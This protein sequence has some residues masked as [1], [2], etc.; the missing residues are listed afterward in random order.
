MNSDELVTAFVFLIVSITG[1]LVCRAI[2]HCFS[3]P[4]FSTVSY[5]F[6]FGLTVVWGMSQ[7]Q[8]VDS[9]TPLFFEAPLPA[10][11]HNDLAKWIALLSLLFL[12]Y[13]LPKTDKLKWWFLS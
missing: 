2:S 1:F 9:G 13:S 6:C 3:G 11:E 10:L 12:G 5:F 8:I 7:L 4:R